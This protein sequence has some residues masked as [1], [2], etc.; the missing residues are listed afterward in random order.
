MGQFQ[1]GR[2]K[3][4]KKEIETLLSALARFGRLGDFGQANRDLNRSLVLFQRQRA[5]LDNIPKPLLE[6][7]NYSL[8]TIFLMLKNKDWVAIADIV[9]FELLSLWREISS[10]IDAK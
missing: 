1:T 3:S 4:E 5:N 8:E 10:S 2:M 6:K 7:L 9:D